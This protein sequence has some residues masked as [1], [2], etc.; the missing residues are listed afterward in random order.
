MAHV[1]PAHIFGG[2]RCEKQIIAS[3]AEGWRE[4]TGR[5][6]TS[7]GLGLSFHGNL[8]RVSPV[9]PFPISIVPFPVSTAQDVH[10]IWRQHG[11]PMKFL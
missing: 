4:A 10:R 3:R 2:C 11:T 8:L 7:L 6:G 5:I 9:V 1:A